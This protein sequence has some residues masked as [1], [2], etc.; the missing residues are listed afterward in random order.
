M[1]KKYILFLS[2]FFLSLVV[3]SSEEEIKGTVKE[4]NTNQPIIGANVYWAGTTI[5]TTTDID[6][7][8]SLKKQPE[9]YEKLIVSFVGY[10]TDTIS[11]I[12]FSDDFII[13]LSPNIEL[14]EVVVAKRQAGSYYSSLNPLQSQKVTGAELQ[15]AACCNLSES[16]E[17][18]ASIDVAYS[19]AVTGAKQIK[20]MG[21]S[22]NYV[23]TINENMPSMRG[24]AA[25]FGLGYTP[26][27]WMESIQ[28]SKGTAS[29]VNGYEAVTGQI[30]VEYKKP[31]GQEKFH[32]NAYTND[33]G[34]TELNLNGAHSFNDS[35]S[36]MI[37]F[38]G[39]NLSREIDDNG[40]QFLDIPKIRQVNFMNRWNYHTPKAH[41]TLDLK[42]LDE[43][44]NTGQL[45]VDINNTATGYGIQLGTKRYEVVAKN[46]IIFDKP[47]TSLGIQFAGSYHNQNSVYGLKNYRG[48]QYNEYL[49]VIFQSHLSSEMHTYKVGA[50]FMG[51][52]L[53]ETLDEVT[54]EHLEYVPGVFAEYNLNMHGLLSVIVGMRADYS[55]MHG[56]FF[57]PRLHAKVNLTEH[58]IFRSS[59][60][61]GYRTTIPLAE[62]NYFL[63]SSR[64]LEIAGNLKQEEALNYGA[65]ISFKIPVNN[66]TLNV[67]LDYYRTDFANQVVRDLDKDVH[68]LY[69]SNLN[70]ESYSNAFQV[71]LNG[72]VLPRL[73]ATLAYRINDVKQ[74]TNG[75]L[76]AAPLI[77]KSKGLISLSYATRMDKW[78]FD[79]TAQINGGGRMPTPDVINP[80][81]NNSFDPYNVF[82]AQVTKN[83]KRWSFYFGGENLWGFTM[84]N[85]IIDATDPWGN[86][87]DGSMIWG[88]IH[89][90]KLYLGVRY[91]IKEY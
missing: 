1:M 58:I 77:S 60:G 7:Q 13:A 22:G 31:N 76:Q 70:G 56:L 34:K 9:E 47:A 69:L 82:N 23:Q 38:H 61:K 8:F 27:P 89:G 12:D 81:W 39:E 19:D 42:I 20:M 72:E 17:T 74:T 64:K 84:D 35:L 52:Q 2:I 40:D 18:N 36:T 26:G 33:A 41:R 86:S 48:T 90:R 50:S 87:F 53:A 3:Y 5:G 67:M 16:F 83:Y 45:G 88:P 51:D 63:A 32:L 75:I 28:I 29:V 57:T 24:M 66:R 11:I 54:Y 59:I 71:E 79:F 37:L 91:T 15:K 85:P 6:G 4:A 78:Q 43:Q 14:G 65:N 73:S 49:N 62:N 10:H 30:N 44:R 80:L 25:V 55:S 46:G 68:K 21:L